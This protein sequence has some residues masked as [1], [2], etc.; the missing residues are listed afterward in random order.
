MLGTGSVFLW[1]KEADLYVI[2]KPIRFTKNNIPDDL[3]R[4]QSLRFS[5][6]TKNKDLI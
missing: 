6:E 4:N 1:L 2:T 3:Q 5:R